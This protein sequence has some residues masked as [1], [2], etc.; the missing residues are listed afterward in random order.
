MMNESVRHYHTTTCGLNQKIHDLW[1]EVTQ[2]WRGGGRT[3]VQHRVP[4]RTDEV[5]PW[6]NRESVTAIVAR[7]VLRPVAILST[8]TL[9]SAECMILAISFRSCN[10][11]FLSVSLLFKI[12]W[13][14]TFFQIILNNKWVNASASLTNAQASVENNSFFEY[15][16]DSMTCKRVHVQDQHNSSPFWI[17]NL[18]VWSVVEK[19][20]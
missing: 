2:S 9:V 11:R 16:Y 4:D 12:W 3:Q 10:C 18:T 19:S 1:R 17:I 8:D 7:Q 5:K 13:R 20:F 6:C 14:R 15:L